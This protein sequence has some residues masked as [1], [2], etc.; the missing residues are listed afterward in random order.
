MVHAL[1]RC[2]NTAEKKNRQQRI[3]LSLK[4]M[5]FNSGRLTVCFAVSAITIAPTWTDEEAD[6]EEKVM[7]PV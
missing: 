1:E 2:A 7:A 3:S 4:L 6:E 5:T